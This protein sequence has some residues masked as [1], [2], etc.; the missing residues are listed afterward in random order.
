VKEP[1]IGQ[2]KHPDQLLAIE[3]VG[4][5]LSMGKKDAQ[6]LMVSGD[7]PVA[8]KIGKH[9][10][11]RREDVDEY[12]RRKKEDMEIELTNQFNPGK[13]DPA[14]KPAVDV[15]EELAGVQGAIQEYHGF[16]H[17]HCV[18]FLLQF[19]T[20]IY[21]GKSR[22]IGA[23]VAQHQNGSKDT[24]KKEFNRVLYMVVE[25]DQVNAAEAYYIKTLSPIYNRV[26]VETGD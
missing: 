19:G 18:Y 26:G 16:A 20:V 17:A 1:H 8:L 11:W 7:F 21:V 22:R 12:L 14:P 24:P 6:R 13:V 25:A 4:W 3:D 2:Q 9:L 15:P 23:R 5:L 10:R